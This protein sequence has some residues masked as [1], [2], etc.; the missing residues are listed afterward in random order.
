MSRRREPVPRAFPIRLDPSSRRPFESIARCLHCIGGML[1][2]LDELAAIYLPN[3]NSYRRIVPG[4][5]APFLRSWGLDTRT[6]LCICGGDVTL[7]L[8]LAALVA[9]DADGIRNRMDPGAP[10][11]GDLAVQD[12]ERLLL[13]WGKALDACEA[14]GFRRFRSAALGLGSLK[15]KWRDRRRTKKPENTRLTA[16]GRRADP[17]VGVDS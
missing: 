16:V 7:S 17:T 3:T 9:A 5:F 11:Q 14:S 4:A 13:D 10:A 6:E 15:Q 1:A 12:V 2:H 8:M